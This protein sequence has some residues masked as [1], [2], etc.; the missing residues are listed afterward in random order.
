MQVRYGRAGLE[1]KSK[2]LDEVVE[3]FGYH[4][5][6]AIRA[7]C[8]PVKV[9]TGAPFVIGQPKEYEPEKLLVVLN[10][11]CCCTAK[12]AGIHACACGAA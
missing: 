4:R 12:R 6:A 1:Y 10:A 2:L 8:R 5:M 3:F 11:H 7:L 9:G